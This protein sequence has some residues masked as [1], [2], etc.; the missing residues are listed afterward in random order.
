M[1][2]SHKPEVQKSDNEQ[3]EFV[4]EC[5]CLQRG[6]SLFHCQSATEA[7]KLS[8]CLW[9]VTAE[10]T[11]KSCLWKEADLRSAIYHSCGLRSVRN[12]FMLVWCSAGK[13]LG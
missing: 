4:C 10:V 1:T 8:M 12:D 9:S 3:I 13:C 6:G 11:P 7:G 2:R 5:V